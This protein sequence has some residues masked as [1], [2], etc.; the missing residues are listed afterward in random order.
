MC[1]RGKGARLPERRGNAP[2]TG[3]R[4]A[5]GGAERGPTGGDASGTTPSPHAN[6][7]GLTADRA[8]GIWGH[9]GGGE[10]RVGH[11]GAGPG[12]PHEA[13]D[14][15]NKRGPVAAD[16]PRSHQTAFH[17]H[18][19]MFSLPCTDGLEASPPTPF[20]FIKYS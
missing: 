1:T 7:R 12:H 3:G 10:S 16:S 5:D 2:P 15:K 17:G 20:L 8:P 9:G 4:A 6:F 13:G 14:T 11:G 18:L 19:C